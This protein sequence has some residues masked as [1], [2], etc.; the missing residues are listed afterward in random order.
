MG[1]D[2]TIQL[3]TLHWPKALCPIPSA[4]TTDHPQTSAEA[5]AAAAAEVP[6]PGAKPLQKQL[7]RLQNPHLQKSSTRE[8]YGPLPI[9]LNDQSIL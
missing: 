7:P 3:S 2:G 6:A 9:Q 1:G 8:I 5:P 4:V